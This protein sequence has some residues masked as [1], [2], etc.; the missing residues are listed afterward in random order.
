MRD[1]GVFFP[2]TKT[3]YSQEFNNE[4]VKKT[5]KNAIN[6]IDTERSSPL[7]NLVTGPGFPAHTLPG[8]HA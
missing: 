3:F 7:L 4:H 1:C 6:L 2:F 8:L 5:L